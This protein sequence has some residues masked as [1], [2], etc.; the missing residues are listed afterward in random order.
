MDRGASTT[1]GDARTAGFWGVNSNGVGA[2][3]FIWEPGDGPN[4]GTGEPNDYINRS[5]TDHRYYEY[6][7]PFNGSK[8]ELGL[9]IGDVFGVNVN[10]YDT[11]GDSSG[12]YVGRI[13]STAGNLSG[14]PYQKFMLNGKPKAVLNEVTNKLVYTDDLLNF[15]GSGSSDPEDEALTYH[16]D[17][18]YDGENFI[19]E[20]TT[21]TSSHSYPEPGV[22]TIAFKVED[23]HGGSDIKTVTIEIKEPLK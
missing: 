12:L 9:Q 2:T 10:I 18:D 13:P 5:F 17:F 15:D 19:D 7:I 1:G 3:M 6:S 8:D 23:P 16:W 11:R 20:A 14:P 22:Y 21:P 4:H